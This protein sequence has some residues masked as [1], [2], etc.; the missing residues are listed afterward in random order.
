MTPTPERYRE[1]Q[2]AL[3]DKGYY[4]GAIDGS[5]DPECVEALKR[6]QGDQNLP[7]DGKLGARSLIGLGLGPRHEPLQTQ[8]LSKPDTPTP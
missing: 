2:Q 3:A 8:F 6:F 1:V 7:V 4:N 5:W